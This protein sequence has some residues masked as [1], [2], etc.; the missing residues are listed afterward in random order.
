MAEDSI[1]LE[2]LAILPFSW[3]T[4]TTLGLVED[5]IVPFVDAGQTVWTAGNLTFSIG[6]VVAVAALLFVLLHRDASI[7][8]TSGV[9]AWIVYATIGLVL[10]PPLFPALQDT[11]AQTPAA[12]VA[13]SVQNYGFGIASWL[14]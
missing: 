12:L 6:A 10:A 14:N 2:L 7:K 8:D 11:L 1:D 3:G 4:A 13:F 9:D 5:T